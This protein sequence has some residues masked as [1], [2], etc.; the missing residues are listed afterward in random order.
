MRGK[1][2]RRFAHW[3]PFFARSPDQPQDFA[4][5]LI[6]SI[7]RIKR[8]EKRD[9]VV[10]ALK[11]VEDAAAGTQSTFITVY[12]EVPGSGGGEWKVLLEETEL[13]LKH[14][15]VRWQLTPVCVP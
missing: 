6:P 10:V 13:P 3:S 2:F 9:S 4:P 5:T 14:K 1:A 15:F 7:I 8:I 12:G 11:S